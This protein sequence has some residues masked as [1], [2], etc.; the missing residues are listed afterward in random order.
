MLDI[1]KQPR[2]QKTVRLNQDEINMINAF[3]LSTGNDFSNAMRYIFLQGFENINK[4]QEIKDDVGFLISKLERQIE[5]LENKLEEKD[6]KNSKINMH[7]L[8]YAAKNNSLAKTFESKKSGM[9][10]EDFKVF[11]DRVETNSV[12]NMFVKIK[13][14]EEKEDELI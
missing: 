1:R 9:T 12:K 14:V 3:A 10:P 6:K 13:E 2:I 11:V 5:S 4:A 7:I 8:K